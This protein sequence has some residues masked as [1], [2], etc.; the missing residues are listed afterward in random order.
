MKTLKKD[1]IRALLDS[2]GKRYHLM[3]P[4]RE[5]NGDILFDTYRRNAFT[6]DYGKPPLPPKGV[7]FPQTEEIFSVQDGTY[8]ESISAGNVLLF[9]IRACDMCGILQAT[10]FMTRDRTDV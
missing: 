4:A 2:W 8:R 3:A 7:F 1:E 9:G 6:L 10:S 5:K